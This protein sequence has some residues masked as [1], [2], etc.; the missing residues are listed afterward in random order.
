MKTYII[1][2]SCDRVWLGCFDLKKQKLYATTEA[3][4]EKDVYVHEGGRI[5]DATGIA[6]IINNA[7]KTNHFPVPAIS[8][9]NAII[10]FHTKYGS[11]KQ[12]YEGD[13]SSRYEDINELTIK[14]GSAKLVSDKNELN[15]DSYDKVSSIANLLGLNLI[16]AADYGQ[17][18]TIPY[19]AEEAAEMF[20]NYK[21]S[22]DKKSYSIL[23][24]MI[25]LIVVCGV[26]VA[27][28][29]IFQK[30]ID[31]FLNGET[32]LL[33]EPLIRELPEEL[34]AEDVTEDFDVTLSGMNDTTKRNGQNAFSYY[35]L[36]LTDRNGK[37]LQWEVSADTYALIDYRYDIGDTITVTKH[38]KGYYRYKIGDCELERSKEVPE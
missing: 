34:D 6:T 17:E 20:G 9:I 37:T 25:G 19:S 2:I 22:K 4:L 18:N 11:T 33:K 21:V 14:H 38:S 24:F 23:P 28:L 30:P 31:K 3:V 7:A 8:T 32:P 16:F 27:L 29:C 35:Y 13:F 10:M 36:Y 1:D 12:A 26:L 5:A 15:E